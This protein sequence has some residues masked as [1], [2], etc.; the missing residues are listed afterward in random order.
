ML[1]LTVTAQRALHTELFKT[2]QPYTA[3]EIQIQIKSSGSN[4]RSSNNNNNIYQEKCVIYLCLQIV[5][6]DE[7]QYT[8]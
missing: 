2:F 6:P 1:L 4:N 5:S 8:E 3:Q 7:S